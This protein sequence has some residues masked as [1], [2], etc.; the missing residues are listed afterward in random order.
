MASAVQK[1]PC[2]CFQFG[3]RARGGRLIEDGPFS[4]FDFGFGRI[5]KVLDIFFIE[6]GRGRCGFRQTDRASL[7]Q[8]KFAQPALQTLTPASQ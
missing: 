7:K 6:N 5:L 1:I 8:L 3:D 4:L 2:V